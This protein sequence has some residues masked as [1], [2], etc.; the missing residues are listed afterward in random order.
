[1]AWT[2]GSTGWSE[3]QAGRERLRLSQLRRF[4]STPIRQHRTEH[5]GGREGMP[6]RISSTGRLEWREADDHDHDDG[7]DDGND[8]RDAFLFPAC[9]PRLPVLFSRVLK[10]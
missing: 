2:N 9:S 10:L 3:V 1:M 7:D 6:C 5:G 8:D 4:A